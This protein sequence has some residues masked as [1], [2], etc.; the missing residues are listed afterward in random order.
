MGRLRAA[1]RPTNHHLPL[2]NPNSVLTAMDPWPRAGWRASTTAGIGLGIG[3]MSEC[4]QSLDTPPVAVA[5]HVRYATPTSL[6][7]PRGA[8]NTPP[9]SIAA[10][11]GPVYWSVTTVQHTLQDRYQPLSGPVPRGF[12]DRVGKVVGIFKKTIPAF[13][14]GLRT[15]TRWFAARIFRHITSSRHYTLQIHKSRLA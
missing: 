12:R 13:G 11:P 15:G 4:G 9:P 5:T 10:P 14:G 3:N 7:Q 8:D 2:R 1:R 6:S